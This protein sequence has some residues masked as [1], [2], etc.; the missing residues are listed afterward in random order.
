[1]DH[2]QESGFKNIIIRT[3]DTDVLVIAVAMIHNLGN[4]QFGKGAYCKYILVNALITKLGSTKS[5]GLPIFHDITGCDTCW[6][7]LGF[8]DIVAYFGYSGSI[9]YCQF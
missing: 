7:I 8:N 1:M 9:P 6:I 2:A 3:E 5:N 4:G